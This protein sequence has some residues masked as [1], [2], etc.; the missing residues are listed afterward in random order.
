MN[1]IIPFSHEEASEATSEEKEGGS[2][3]ASSKS[4]EAMIKDEVIV[5]EEET[6]ANATNSSHTDTSYATE[7]NPR[8]SSPPSYLYQHYELY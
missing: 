4:A 3:I 5:E 6:V 2:N 1:E 7:R 8:E